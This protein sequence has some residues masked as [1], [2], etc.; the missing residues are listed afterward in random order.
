MAQVKRFEDMTEEEKRAR[1]DT[2]MVS[3]EA[4]KGVSAIRR[5][6]MKALIKAHQ[7]EYDILVA[8]LGGK[9][10]KKV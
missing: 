9:P 5:A 7:A 4:R 2:W 6:A 8:K 10:A 3:R 1:F